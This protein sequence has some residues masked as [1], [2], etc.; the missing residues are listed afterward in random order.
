MR[1]G[2]FKKRASEGV[3]LLDGA[4]GSNLRLAGMPVGVSTEQWVYDH[5]EAILR[6]QRAYVEAGSDIIYA[7]TFMANRVGLGMH[8]IEDRL[9]ALNAGLVKLS[10][11]AADGRALV[12]GDITTTGKPLEP[13]GPMSYQALFDV[14]REQIEALAA[15]GVDLLVAETMMSIDET[16]CAVEAAASVC[17]LPIMC[18]LTMEADGHLLLGG[19]AE[20]AVETLQALGACAVGLNCSV[21]PDQLE[22]VVRSMKA[23]AEVPVIAKPNAGIPVMDEHGIAHYSMTP[24]DFAAAMRRLMDAGAGIVGGCCGTNPDYIRALKAVI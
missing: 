5:P 7:P 23:V 8:G 3:I 21:G 24:G 4:T 10:K 20:E 9:K 13:V 17:D 14:Y 2:E 1:I 19:S 12:A 22:A 18:S 15:A 6:L 11:E 16:V